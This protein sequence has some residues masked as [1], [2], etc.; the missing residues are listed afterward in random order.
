MSA[1]NHVESV[2]GH[3]SGSARTVR[4]EDIVTEIQRLMGEHSIEAVY[5]HRVLPHRTRR[6]DLSGRGTKVEILHTLLGIELKVGEKRLLCPD[7]ATA[8]YLSVFAR[9]G[10]ETLAVPYDITQVSRLADELESS[11]H[12]MMLLVEHLTSGRSER[13]RAVVRRRLV[14]ETREK[15]AKLGGGALYPKFDQ[16]TRQRR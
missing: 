11:W 9:L 12:R 8:R 5:E 4:A 7:L 1:K 2:A 16:S 3:L 15:I 10:C 6:Y 13:L 14:L